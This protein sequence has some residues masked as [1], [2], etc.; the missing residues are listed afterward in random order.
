MWNHF[1]ATKMKILFLVLEMIWVCNMPLDDCML[2]IMIFFSRIYHITGITDSET[3]SDEPYEVPHLNQGAAVLNKN[4]LWIYSGLYN[5]SIHIYI[6]T[7]IGSYTKEIYI[8][9]YIYRTIYT[10]YMST[11]YTNLF[12]KI[13]II[14]Y[15]TYNMHRQS[16][17]RYFL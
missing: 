4:V 15:F 17:S 13:Q 12:I 14:S 16:V 11:H 3:C 10:N 6:T 8:Y 5:I 2:H 9:I 7:K 1:Y